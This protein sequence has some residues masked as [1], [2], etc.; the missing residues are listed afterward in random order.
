MYS[1]RKEAVEQEVNHF[2][3][4]MLRFLFTQEKPEGQGLCLEYCPKCGR[5]MVLD[6]PVLMTI[7]KA[8]M[9][10][11]PSLFVISCQH[12]ANGQPCVSILPHK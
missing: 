12:F 3:K 7:I 6:E 4:E 9:P 8:S 10:E 5:K 2:L 1:I 11:L